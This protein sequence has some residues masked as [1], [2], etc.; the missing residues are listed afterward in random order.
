MPQV[1]GLNG[2]N[3]QL[4]RLQ[5]IKPTVVKAVKTENLRVQRNAVLLCPSNHGELRH[6]IKTKTEATESM[7]TGTTY[8]NKEYA[9]YVEFGTG[10]LGQ[11]NH[12]GITPEITP[13]YTQTSWWFPGKDVPEQ[14]AA[15]YH[16]PKMT[17]K[18]GD[19]LYLTQGQPAQPFM[20]PAIKNNEQAI[21]NSI[22]GQLR[23]G[24]IHAVSRR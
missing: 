6:S 8:T 21:R 23:D 9:A 13:A 11:A 19:V 20:Y 18:N 15:K 22:A 14:D 4:E 1:Q 16:W 3:R 10:P 17:A 5:N 24:I 2:L 12:S 7:V